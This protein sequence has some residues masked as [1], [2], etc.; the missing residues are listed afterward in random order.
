LRPTESLRYARAA[1]DLGLDG[2]VVAPPPYAVPN[3]DEVL[4]FYRWLLDQVQLPACI[5]NWPRGTNLDLSPQLL[6][7]LAELET[8]VALKNSTTSASSFLD[9]F[10]ALKDS[11]RIFG[12]G[13]DERS[14]TLI[15]D[16]GGDGTIGAG[17]VLGHEHPAFWEALWRGDIQEAQ[18]WGAR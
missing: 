13:S 16:H 17:A 18:H 2:I 10:F 14:I 3:D 12:F 11:I 7:R 8:V 1:V 4:A 6:A 9:T 5:Y 15:T